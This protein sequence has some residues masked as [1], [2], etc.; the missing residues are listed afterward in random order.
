MWIIPLGLKM[1]G[2]RVSHMLSDGI[3]V[4]MHQQRTYWR[5]LSNNFL[6]TLED[7]CVKVI[8][9][10]TGMLYYCDDIVV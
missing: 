2:Y 6:N 4:W 3:H 1:I 7:K 10:G 9:N 5:K 8:E